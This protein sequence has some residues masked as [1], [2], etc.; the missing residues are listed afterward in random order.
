MAQA[1]IQAYN[2]LQPA[3]I[4]LGLANLTGVTHNRR[5][6]FSP[7]VQ[8]GTI[9]PNLGVIRVDSQSGDIIA[10][11]WNFAI[12]GIC[13][14]SPNM[15][16]SG[17]IMGVASDIVEK[18]IGGVAL[19]MNGDAGDINPN[20]NMCDSAPIFVGSGVI[21]TAV[22][23]LRSS[24][25]TYDTAD[26]V[27]NSKY[28][29]FGMTDLNATFSRFDNC[30]N[31]GYLDICT[32]CA[33][34]DC[35]FNAHLNSAWVENYPRFTAFRFTIN[36]VTTIFTS[37]PGEA[38]VELGWWIR[39]DTKDLG[40]DQTF[41]IGYT[42]SHMGYF[43]TPDEYDIGGYESQLTFWGIGTAEKVREGCY[44]VTSPL[45]NSKKIPTKLKSRH[46]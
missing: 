25:K 38:L 7:Y 19:F 24:I 40:F 42:N 4:G 20:G 2:S 5:A 44:S 45:S 15:Y 16:F 43:C 22:A 12:H 6:Y 41:L 36:N 37:I 8:E 11:A 9:D 26:I 21:A 27:G 32:F 35:D 30:T 1:L 10:T 23:N 46:S 13:Y 39:N 3:V 29:P 14:Y 18:N 17:D 34:L 28:V 31:G 33:W